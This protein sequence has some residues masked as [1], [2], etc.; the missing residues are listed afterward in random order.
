[1]GKK[2]PT[3]PPPPDPVVTARAQTESNLETAR[4][5]ARFNRVNQITPYGNLT[6]NDLGGDRW[7]AVQ[8]LSPAEQAALDRSNEAQRLYSEA[9]LGQ[10]GRVQDVLSRPMDISGLPV[11]A[12]RP[13][14]TGIGDANQ[15]RDAVEAALMQR[16][17]P[18]LE[19]DR[20]ALEARLAA[21]GITMGSEQWNRGMDDFARQANDARLGVI[22]NAGQEQSRVFGLGF[23]QA[24]FN[25]QARAQGLQEAT[26]LRQMPLN[27]AQALLTGSTVQSP[28]FVSVPGVQVAPTDYMGA[29]DRNY[30]GQMAAWRQRAEDIRSQNQ[31]AA[32]L[33]G[34]VLGGLGSFGLGAAGS[35]LGL[36]AKAAGNIT[37]NS[38]GQGVG[39]FVRS[40]FS[41]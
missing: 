35:A 7:E 3:A 16:L 6:Y 28:Q 4:A 29:V 15:S 32:Q 8:T 27:E 18:V 17:N 37:A 21:Q 5:N 20:A 11:L 9:A 13:D 31:M 40:A 33:G 1:M 22:A 25:N 39:R 19:R 24:A 36:S 10:L 41:Y 12:S 34:L 30:Q 14:F 38:I 26:A 23:N 2:T